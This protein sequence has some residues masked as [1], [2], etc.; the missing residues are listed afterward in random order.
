MSKKSLTL[1]NQNEKWIGEMNDVTILLTPIDAE[2]FKQFQKNY[3]LFN[4]LVSKGVFEQKNATIA[5]NFDYLG[6]LQTI[7]R[8]DFLFNTRHQ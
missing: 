4:L 6:Q 7:E 5:L 1:K 2:R 3:D 8:H